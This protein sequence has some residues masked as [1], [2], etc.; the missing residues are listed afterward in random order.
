MNISLSGR[1]LNYKQPRSA[2]N[3]HNKKYFYDN[4]IAKSFEH[5]RH[6]QEL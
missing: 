1:G 6:D 4:F 3:L 5:I 2:L